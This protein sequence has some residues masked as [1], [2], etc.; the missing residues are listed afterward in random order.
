VACQLP[1]NCPHLPPLSSTRFYIPRYLPCMLQ[2]QSM[3]LYYRNYTIQLLVYECLLCIRYR[4]TMPSLRLSPYHRIGSAR[5][6]GLMLSRPKGPKQMRRGIP[7]SKTTLPSRHGN[8]LTMRYDGVWVPFP[9]L[10]SFNSLPSFS[11]SLL[12]HSSF[13][14]RR[15]R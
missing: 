8:R 2:V 11:P 5:G 1:L 13:F 12:I 3:C 4:R 9:A 14:L 10:R 15:I 6:H 7:K